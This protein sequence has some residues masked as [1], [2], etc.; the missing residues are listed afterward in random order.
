MKKYVELY[1]KIKNDIIDGSIECG[2]KLPSKRS[3]AELYNVS[4]ITVETAYDVLQSEGYIE[5]RERSGYF[6]CY[7]SSD[8]IN[9]PTSTGLDFYGD[10]DSDGNS[11]N[12][13]KPDDI[14]SDKTTESF[15]FS[16]YAAAVRYTLNDKSELL[17]RKTDGCGAKEL[18]HAL[19]NYLKTSRN[20][21]TNEKNIIIGSGAE[22]LYGLILK[23]LGN[24]KVYAIES[25]SYEKIEDVYKQNGI[26]PLKLKLGKDGILS[27]QL[28]KSNAQI[29]HVTPYRSYPTGVTASASKKA[30]Y[31]RYIAEKKGY[32]IEDDYE[33]EFSLSANLTETLFG[34][35]DKNVIYVN[36]FS[37]TIFPSIRTAYMILPDELLKT[38]DELF[39]NSSCTVPALEQYVLAKI[40]SDGSFGRHLN[41][42]R[43]L[44][45]K[46]K[47]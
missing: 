3:A 30:E 11:E 39:K 40:I 13:F 20:I 4:V 18:R 34:N 10:S 12:Y 41:K 7:R 32:I 14:K 45:R 22:Y 16:A 43:R 25:P 35:S 6:V 28:K 17:T 29:L 1:N 23:I 44:R 38:Y 5:S 9:A 36:T 37:K 27:E 47:T 42:V 31:L 15:S 8:V 2:K 21:I 46:T 33:S 19:K 26:V 24:D